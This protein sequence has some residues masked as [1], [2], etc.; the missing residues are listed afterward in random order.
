MVMD[1]CDAAARMSTAVM[2][3]FLFDSHFQRIPH[4][5]ESRD[6]HLICV[7]GTLTMKTRHFENTFHRDETLRE[8]IL[9]RRFRS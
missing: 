6:C 4:V 2:L 9:Q 3:V 5:E 1:I 7:G 8:H